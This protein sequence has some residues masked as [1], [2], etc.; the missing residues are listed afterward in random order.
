MTE[1][2]FGHNSVG[3]RED[4]DFYAYHEDEYFMNWEEEDDGFGESTEDWDEEE[5][6]FI[7]HYKRRRRFNP[8]EYN[9]VSESDFM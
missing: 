1:A 4:D 2:N 9:G 5:L 6:R 7:P 3:K 8:Y